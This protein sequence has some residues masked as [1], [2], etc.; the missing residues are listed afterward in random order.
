MSQI[1]SPNILISLFKSRYSNG[2]VF[3]SFVKKI[4]NI[5]SRYLLLLVLNSP[6]SSFVYSCYYHLHYI[7][8]PFKT[9]SLWKFE[10]VKGSYFWFI[11]R[12]LSKAPNMGCSSLHHLLGFLVWNMNLSDLGSNEAVKTL[13]SLI[14]FVTQETAEEE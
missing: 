5:I 10:R 4:F 12:P 11:Q 2:C 8:I 14:L 1:S 3:Y 13:L 9:T 6:S 7:I